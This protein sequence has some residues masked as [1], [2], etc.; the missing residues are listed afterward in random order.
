MLTFSY[1]G[2]MEPISRFR[3]H[4]P[5]LDVSFFTGFIKCV[6]QKECYDS[7]VECRLYLLHHPAISCKRGYSSNQYRLSYNSVDHFW[8]RCHSHVLCEKGKERVS[9]ISVGINRSL[10]ELVSPDISPCNLKPG[11]QIHGCRNTNTYH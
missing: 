6:V 5:F 7:L 11:V 9:D 8:E 3:D 2:C 1:V 4:H 10:H